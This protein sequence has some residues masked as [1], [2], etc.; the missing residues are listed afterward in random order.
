MDIAPSKIERICGAALEEPDRHAAL[1][2]LSTALPELESKTSG[3]RNEGLFASHELAT[4]VPNR[5]DWNT[6]VTSSKRLLRLRDKDLLKGLGFSVEQLPGPAYLL[7]ATDS[8]AALAILLDRNE[9][10][11]VANARFSNLSP[12]SFA[13]AKADSENLD[14]VVVLAGPVVRLY[15][16][17]TGVGTGQRGRTETYAEIHL[18][19]LPEDQSGYLW[20][21]FSAGALSKGGS[22]AE[23]LGNSSR[24]AVELGVRLRERIYSEVVPPLAQGMMQARNLTHPTA[25]DLTDTY[26]MALIVLFRLLFIAYAEDKELLPYKTN[27]LYRA[28]SLKQ[29]ATDLTKHLRDQKSFGEATTAHWE[30]VERLFRAVDQGNAEWGVPAYNGGLFSSDSNVSAIGAA[31]AKLLLRDNVFGPVLAALLVDRT[32][33]GFGPVDF[34]SLGVRE[35]GTVYEGLLENELSIAEVDLT[36]EIKDKQERYRPAKPK[37]DVR[38]KSGQ[39]FSTTPLERVSQLDLILRSTL[40]WSTFWITAW[41]LHSRIIW[42]VWTL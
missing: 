13:L 38:V 28:R 17:K 36:T 5:T 27:D 18:D 7:R 9:S 20:L 25:T 23:I 15:P 41:S 29:K 11:D 32:P 1:R 4:G 14:Y 40:R 16:V 30:E 6:A 22:V 12:I 2:F 34:R 24:Y 19:L 37:D 21:I 33:E 3:L 42:C 39:D 35:F 10:P 8:R 31:L 26:Q